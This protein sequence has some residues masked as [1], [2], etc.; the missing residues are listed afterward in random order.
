MEP[1]CL[2][3]WRAKSN[4]HAAHLLAPEQPGTGG[5]SLLRTHRADLRAL[6]HRR[7]KEALEEARRAEAARA[8]ALARQAATEAKKPSSQPAPVPK[9]QAVSRSD[10]PKA[11]PI[12]R[13]LAAAKLTPT[14]IVEKPAPLPTPAPAPPP[15]DTAH[16][17]GKLDIER[18]LLAGMLEG[19]EEKGRKFLSGS[20]KYR[21]NLEERADLARQIATLDAQIAARDGAALSEN[22]SNCTPDEIATL[23]K[24]WASGYSARQIAEML[25]RFSR[26]AVIGKARRLGLPMQA[27]NAMP[28]RQSTENELPA[29]S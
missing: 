13:K 27:Q 14:A 25:G 17:Y 12:L 15:C 19:L 10:L 3:R 16:P 5:V 29:E 1:L 4:H 6:A 11:S 28:A 8:E 9:A 24:A 21:R 7:A 2:V 22:P 23:R 18:D 26:N 20:P